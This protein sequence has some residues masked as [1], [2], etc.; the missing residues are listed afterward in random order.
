M[1]LSNLLE[2]LINLPPNLDRHIT[3]LAIDSR[4]ISPGEV[5]IALVGNQ[6]TGEIYIESALQ[7]GAIVIL[8]E[9]PSIRLEQLANDI[10]C[11]SLPQLSQR[12]GEMTAQ[13]Y[14]YPS[15][16][17]RI[18]GVTG[19][20]GKTSVTH[21]LAQILSAYMPC[22]LI[23]TLGYG[24][25]GALQP[26]LHTTPDA[27][28]LQTW[29]A[30]FREQHR[31]AVAMEVSS[32]ALVQGRVNGVI[33]ETAVLTNLSRDHLDYHHTMTA[34]GAAK[35]QLFNWP[36]LKTA[37]INYDDPFGQQILANLPPSVT[38]LTYSIQHPTTS[39]YAHIQRYDANGCYLEIHSQWGN[40]TLV[41]PLFG[42]FNVS[43]LLAAITVLLN[44]GLT[45][46]Q[47]LPQLAT[48][49]AVP[50]R[51]E[52]FGSI[53]HPTVIVD[54][55]HTP[56]ALE[57]VLI[58]LREHCQFTP[59]SDTNNSKLWCVFGCGG[60]RDRG[61]RS[62]MGEIAQRY[63]DKVIITDDNPRHESSQAIINDIL[64]GCSQPEAVIPERQA[65]IRYVLQQAKVGDVVLIAGKGHEDYQQIGEQ[66]LPFSDRTLVT[67]LLTSA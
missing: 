49:R 4:E 12:V 14:H 38:P 32:H 7:Q 2:H 5:F 11:I 66:R 63:A 47:L 62:L 54:Y 30:Q 1:R 26:S 45:L 15:R 46:P 22:G 24:T 29:L 60:N 9:A 6:T 53:N 61:K 52:R 28:R 56:D 65:A 48:I 19:T 8:K 35:Q 31:Q 20:N 43:N 40:G 36:N 64:Q 57:K 25:Y 42:Q 41:S 55:A 16:D 39:V 27:I 17:L 51:M 33:F 23:G 50:G 3:G 13:F 58:A 34:Y 37:V 67:A 21:M 18:I 59:S 10:P 44:M